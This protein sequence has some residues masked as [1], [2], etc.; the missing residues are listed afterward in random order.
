MHTR[1]LLPDLG[2]TGATVSIWYAE[3]GDQVLEG[4]RVVEVLLPGATFEITAPTSG[5]LIAKRAYP[6]DRVE[7]GQ[8]LGSIG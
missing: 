3:P 5:K 7:A 8:E 2:T 4:E 1:I 6:G